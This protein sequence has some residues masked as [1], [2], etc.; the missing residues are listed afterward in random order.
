MSKEST[1]KAEVKLPSRNQ[2]RLPGVFDVTDVHGL[3]QADEA[4][5]NITQDGWAKSAWVPLVTVVQMISV[6]KKRIKKKDRNKKFNVGYNS[7][8]HTQKATPHAL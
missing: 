8:L 3:V 4:K 2:S 6:E 7:A 1:G 5:V